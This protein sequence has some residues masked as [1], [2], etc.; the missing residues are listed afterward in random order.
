MRTKRKIM[1]AL[2]FSGKLLL[3]IAVIFPLI[4][5]FCLSFMGMADILSNPPVLISKR[6]SLAN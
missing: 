1:E 6:M 2:T 3:G 4:Y 5:G